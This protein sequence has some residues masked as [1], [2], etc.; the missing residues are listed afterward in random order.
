[1]RYN[2]RKDD[3]FLNALSRYVNRGPA[4]YRNHTFLEYCQKLKPKLVE[5]VSMIIDYI[6]KGFPIPKRFYIK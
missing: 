1:M 2:L 4:I 5:E 6:N 3:V